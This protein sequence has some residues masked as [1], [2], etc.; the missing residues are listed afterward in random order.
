VLSHAQLRTRLVRLLAGTVGERLRLGDG[1][2]ASELDLQRATGLARDLVA[3]YG[4]SEAVGPVRLLAPDADVHLG[5]TPRLVPAGQAVLDLADAELRRAVDDAAEAAGD[6]LRAHGSALDALV[7]ALVEAEHVEGASLS[8]LLDGVRPG[9]P[10]R[11][12]APAAAPSR[13]RR[14]AARRERVGG[15]RPAG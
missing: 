14:T 8:T 13:Q 15:S 1:S 12:G 7:A 4:L 10:G 2:T 9:A 6:L 5:G 3:R 11:P